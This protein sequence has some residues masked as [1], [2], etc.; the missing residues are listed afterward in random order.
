MSIP[1]MYGLILFSGFMQDDFQTIF[2]Q[3]QHN[4]HIS[5]KKIHIVSTKSV[6]YVMHL[7]ANVISILI[8][9]NTLY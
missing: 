1:T 8:K 6:A 9:D 5:L 2:C 4:L 7:S 3:N